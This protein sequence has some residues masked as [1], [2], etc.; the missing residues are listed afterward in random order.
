MTAENASAVKKKLEAVGDVEK[1]GVKKVVATRDR[2]AAP[3][4]KV[5][6]AL[7][8]RDFQNLF[9]PEKM[10]EFGKEDAFRGAIKMTFGMSPEALVKLPIGE[11]E[12]MAGVVNGGEENLTP[13]FVVVLQAL[14]GLSDY[15]FEELTRRGLFT[16]DRKLDEKKF[17]DWIA[18]NK[19]E[20]E[21]GDDVDVKNLIWSEEERGDSEILAA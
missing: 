21:E 3:N 8:S 17:Y 14:A 6:S 20:L 13:E 7:R 16:E 4:I 18:L 19:T 11:I 9:N 5:E 10:N 2:L 12:K 1:V 15:D